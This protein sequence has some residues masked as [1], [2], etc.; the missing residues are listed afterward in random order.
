MMKGVILHG[1]RGTRLAPLT[2]SCPKP[3]LPIANRPMS[4]YALEDLRES[5]ITQI[6]LVVD[7]TQEEKVK[8]YYGNGEKFGV[9][10]TY[11]H[12]DKP[13]GISHAIRL[14]KD[15]IGDDKFVAYLGDNVLRR[16]LSGYLDRFTGSDSA[17][18]ILLCEVDDPQRYGIAEIDR[19]GSQITK[20]I[21]KPENSSSNMAVIGVYFLTPKIFD[22]IDRLKPSKRGEL[23]ITDALDLL[24]TDNKIEY[25][26]ITG[27]WKD[28]G[29]P[30]DIIDANR[31]I[32]DSIGTKNQFL[33][34]S[35]A[36]IRDDIVLGSNTDLSK[37]SKVI[38]PVIIGRN[39]KIGSAVQIGPNVSIGDNCTL[40]H[41]SIDNS[42]VMND[43][44]IHAE[45]VISYSIIAQ[46]SN[47]E[48]NGTLDKKR[49]LL[50]K[51]SNLKL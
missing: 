8:D 13:K 24:M 50:D 20:I 46:H 29:T 34:D 26:V 31:L 15:F 33:I 6:G 44:K 51:H 1:G 2:N 22:V 35:D 21:E 16:G 3:L 14:C 17:A 5:G 28:T 9:D 30:D 12:Q 25:D 39:C 32:L 43:C 36:T 42:I 48:G 27:W 41:C 11:I 10:I 45:I 4:R 18:M 49:L 37:D 19:S 23:E 38:G 7:S 47:I 40:K